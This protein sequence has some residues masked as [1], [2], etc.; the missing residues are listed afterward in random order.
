M[1]A[2]ANEILACLLTAAGIGGITGWLLRHVSVTELRKHIYD[3]TT[4]LQVKDQTL[5][6]TQLELKAK[7][8]TILIYESKLT[9]AEA[10]AQSRLHELTAETERHCSLQEQLL[11]ATRKISALETEQK[12]AQERYRDSDATI[13]AFEHEA[14]QANAARSTAQLA[15]AEKE[16]EVDQLRVR[17]SELES[18]LAKLEL[19]RPQLT[20]ME[21]AQ[22]RVHW[23]EV[24]LSER[25]AQHRTA[26]H[27]LEAQKSALES[28]IVELESAGHKGDDRHSHLRELDAKY[29]K[30]LAQQAADTGVIETQRG[31]IQDLQAALTERDRSLHLQEDQIAV[32][33]RQL[34]E[35]QALHEELERHPEQIRAGLRLR[36]E[37][38]SVVAA[39]GDEAP[40]QL[41]LQMDQGKR[42]KARLKDDLTK[43][44]GIS[45]AQEES[46]NK[47]G[48]FT[49]VQIAK[50]T[51]ADLARIARQLSTPLDRIKKNNWIASAKKQ[52]L[53]KYGE[54]L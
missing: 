7:C 3:V 27:E 16:E 1:T 19:L 23:L 32:L 30:A 47:M 43:I 49:Y 11:S 39:S 26:L 50:W 33:Q 37:Q 28:R 2:L 6:A 46:L 5:H 40:D 38:G 12:A 9:A 51:P 14:R 22:G 35:L 48:T 17:V 36:N 34:R 29:Q 42:P 31:A 54:R 13:A 53:A 45:P 20:E 15:L 10:L 24:Q 21:P 18:H 41:R 8:S 25:D 52:H 4:A 44:R